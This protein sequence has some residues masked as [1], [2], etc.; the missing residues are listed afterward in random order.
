MRRII[1][2]LFTLMISVG[3]VLL[4]VF[5]FRSSYLRLWETMQDFG[6]S[7]AFYF[8]EIFGIENSITPTVNGLSQSSA[9]IPSPLPDDFSGFKENIVTYFGLLF[10]KANLYGWTSHIAGV[11]LDI[12]KASVIIIPCLLGLGST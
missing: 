6:R 7:I 9:N 4:G 5:V 8:C 2:I 3:L 11:M 12:M 1:D 10:S